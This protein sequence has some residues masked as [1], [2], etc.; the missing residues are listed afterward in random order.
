[1]GRGGR[2]F[3]RTDPKRRGGKSVTPVQAPV[4]AEAQG[5]C[6]PLPSWPRAPPPHPCLC[7]S[8]AASRPPPPSAEPSRLSAAGAGCAFSATK[9]P[10]RPSGA[11]AGGRPQPPPPPRSPP[12]LV[13]SRRD[14]DEGPLQSEEEEQA[15]PGASTRA[16]LG[17]PSLRCT[18]PKGA[19][20]PCQKRAPVMAAAGVPAQGR[21][22]ARKVSLFPRP[23][24]LLPQLGARGFFPSSTPLRSAAAAR[25]R[26][27]A[28]DSLRSVDLGLTP[29][30]R[31][32]SR[33]CLPT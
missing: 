2:A 29:S 14:A 22:D 30:A 11:H 10:Q 12:S 26:P 16:P 21:K 13:V 33:R 1:M 23:A 7:T 18:S 5:L 4:R 28:R 20:D 9:E 17:A 25:R 15:P 24:A 6:R 32:G 27:P 3:D 31:Q 8:H 19:A